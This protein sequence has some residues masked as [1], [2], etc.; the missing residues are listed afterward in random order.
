MSS[1]APGQSP[2]ANVDAQPEPRERRYA[3]REEPALTP[4]E[5]TLTI[6]RDRAF[7]GVAHLVLGGL[8]IRSDLTIEH[9]E[10]LQLALDAVLERARESEDVTITLVVKDGEIETAIWPMR[11]GIREELEAPGG[12]SVG[13]RRMLDTLVDGVELAPGDGGDRLKLTKRV[14]AGSR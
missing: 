8:V 4:D 2:R 1:S 7:Y 9:L 5:I 14:Q 6:P 11:D 10:D 12:D 13:L 3:H